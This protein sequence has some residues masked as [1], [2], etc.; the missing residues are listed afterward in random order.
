MP[1]RIE[2]YALIGDCETAALVA[3]DGLALFSPFRFRG[4]FRRAARHAGARSLVTRTVRHLCAEL[5][6]TEL[7]FPGTDLRLI[8][9]VVSHRIIG[10][11]R[12]SEGRACRGVN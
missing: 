11:I 12:R 3:H 1:S 5:N 6:R 9:E 4:M 7:L 8:Y 2:D 10:E